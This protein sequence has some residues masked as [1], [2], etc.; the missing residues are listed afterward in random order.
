MK[1]LIAIIL[2]ISLCAFSVFASG[3]QEESSSAKSDKKVTL[4]IWNSSQ[5]TADFYNEVVTPAFLAQHPEV[6][7]V[8]VLYTPIADFVKKLAVVLPA[9]DVPDLMEIEDS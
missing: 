2:I 7:K 4:T 9:G 1:K 3:S 5:T 6:E 8:E